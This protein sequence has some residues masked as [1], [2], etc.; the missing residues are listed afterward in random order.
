ALLVW[1]L[2]VDMMQPFLIAKIIDDGILKKDLRHVWT[3]GTVMIGLTALYFA[4]GM[5][6]SFYAA[7]VCQSFSYDT[8]KGLFQKI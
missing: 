5:L 6:N 8:R 1:L 7:H 3:W 2:A 4:S